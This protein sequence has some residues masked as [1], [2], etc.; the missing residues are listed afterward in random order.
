MMRA[1]R[2]KSPNVASALMPDLDAGLAFYRD[3][4]GH[5]LIWRNDAAGQAGLRTPDSATEAVRSRVGPVIRGCSNQ[6]SGLVRELLQPEAGRYLWLR[7]KCYSRRSP[8]PAD[9]SAVPR[10]TTSSRS[11]PLALTR[12]RQLRSTRHQAT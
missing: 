10:A 8:P 12:T 9:Q 7:P 1:A 5:E 2:I 11:T 3:R 4:L 6:L